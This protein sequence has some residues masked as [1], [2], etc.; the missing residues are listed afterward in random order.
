MFHPRASAGGQADQ[1]RAQPRAADLD[2]P[3]A[4][5]DHER[6]ENADL[7]EVSIFVSAVVAW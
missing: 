3:A 1:Q 2:G 7:H 5:G 6:A 4:V